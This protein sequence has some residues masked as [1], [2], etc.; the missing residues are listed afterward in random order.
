MPPETLPVTIPQHDFLVDVF[1][2]RVHLVGG[3]VRDYILYGGAGVGRDIDLL[4]T[5]ADYDEVA[6]GL[7]AHGKTNTVGK[8]F[9]VVKFTREGQTFDIAVPRKERRRDDR[10][11]GHRNF[12]IE[13]GPHIPLEED[14]HRRDFTCNSIAMR[15]SDRRLFD[16]HGGLQAIAERRLSMT[17]P[18]SFGDDPLRVLRAAR[19]ASVH[20]FTPDEEIY[21]RAREVPLHE[22]SAERVADELTRLLLES[23]RP[24]RGLDEYWKLTVLEKSFPELYALTLTIQDAIFHPERD[25]QGHHTVW[26][27]TTVTVDAA[28]RLVDLFG[29]D[30]ERALTLL[31]AALLHDAGK[32]QTTRWEYKRGRMTITSAL[33]DSCGVATA[34]GLLERLR[35]ETRGGF[36]LQ[37]TVLRLV[38]YHHR[39]FEL[40]RNRAE[41]SFKTVARLVNDM[42]GE[43]LLLVLL[44]FADRVS[45]EPLPRVEAELDE[46]SRWFLER[47][48]EY[49]ISAAT[50]RPLL[51]G[52]DLLALGVPPGVAMGRYLKQ[53]YEWQLD[54][55]FHTREEGLEVFRRR[56]AG[57][58]EEEGNP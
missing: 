42:A 38:Q 23:P 22:L 8:S 31:L 27:H 28:R 9:A 32:A 13:F 6:A 29:L 54:G 20:E 5:G 48:R 49:N 57:R 40:Y 16:P 34:A 19:F 50:I 47:K 15:L 30:P 52:R 17:A 45:R 11:F 12:E 4:V 35:L 46:I 36:P 10:S 41:I 53:L 21:R 44:D 26:A 25:E 14:L 7:T 2:E 58:R 37:R 18:E 3:T 43:D 24:G 56:C 33:H 1:G 51:L 55:E 39:L